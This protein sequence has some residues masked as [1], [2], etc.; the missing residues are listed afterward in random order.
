MEMAKMAKAA[1]GLL[2]I[3][4]MA[5]A[6]DVPQLNE[7]NIDDVLEHMTLLEKATLVVGYTG[8]SGYSGLPTQAPEGAKELVAGAA[9]ETTYMPRFGI[10]HTVQTDGPAGVR[11]TPIRKGTDQTFYCTAFPT[12]TVLAS[13][14][15]KDLLY[16]VGAA[17]GNETREYGM[18]V[19]LAPG[20]NIMRNPLCGRNF[21]YFSEDPILSGKLATAF[22][23][24]VQ[25]Q[26][27]GV[28]VKHFAVNNQESNRMANDAVVSQRA[29]R[30][31]YLKPFEIVVKEAQPWTIMS[32]YNKVNG[33]YAQENRDL[34][35]TILRD[36]W[37]FEGIVMTDWTATRNTPAQIKAGND[38]MMPGHQ[39]QIDGLMKALES[40]E[41]TEEE[42]D[43]CA[44]RVLQYIVKTPRFK[45]YKY[46]DKP[47]LKLHAQLT[48]RAAANSMVLL[49]NNNR[50][51]PLAKGE[52]VAL[53]GVTSYDFVS[54]GT[55][56]GD[57][58]EAYVIGLDEGLKNVGIRVDKNLESNYEQYI[59]YSEG[60]SR[61]TAG[62]S[63][64][65]GAV[66][67]KRMPEASFDEMT[68]NA[69]A[70]RNDV[71]VITIGRNAGEG[72]DRKI[73]GDFNLTD[74]EQALIDGVC[75][76]FHAEGKRVVVIINA[77]GVIETAS[78]KA[79][80]DAILMAWQPGQEGGNSVADVLVGDV[81]PSGKLTMT[82]PQNYDDHASS[83]N[84][85]RD[86]W[87]N[88]DFILSDEEKEKIPSIGTTYY[89]EGIYVGYRYFATAGVEVSYP[90]GY[91]LSY[92]TFRYTDPQISRSGDGYV[93]TVKVTNTGHVAGRE[94][95]QLYVQAPAGEVERPY[96]ELK[97]FAKTRELQP[98]ESETVRM[99]FSNYDLGYYDAEADE[100]ITQPGL[101]AALIGASS[102][103][104]RQTLTFNA[105][106][107]KTTCHDALPTLKPLKELSLKPVKPGEKALISEETLVGT[108]SMYLN[109]IGY[110]IKNNVVISHDEEGWW[111]GSGEL[112]Q[113][114]EE[115]PDG[116]LM[117]TSVHS[118]VTSQMTIIP[119]TYDKSRVIIRVNGQDYNTTMNRVK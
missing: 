98:G 14:W 7:K 57:V 106:T 116:S 12:A 88:N 91:G 21:E 66:E 9:G 34:L 8:G 2:L 108:W 104:I 65:D 94:V 105:R 59:K 25:N 58:N 52:R 49:K 70:Q 93:A 62:F 99:T 54:G 28:S 47:D 75:R 51:L 82:F 83:K 89:E 18:D 61:S 95:V 22:V 32:A 35:T 77:G 24:G 80:P 11:I 109:I 107:Q 53:F 67:I 19:L 117:S 119:L 113:K 71:A 64:V 69:F 55:G 23:N 10:P 81:N 29:L 3:S 20:I 78:W 112:R 115:M 5:M 36:E 84:F 37:G 92:T 87:F 79:K 76:A 40:G 1:A 13:S 4:G 111:T 17:M 27:V 114:M 118:G 48:R 72:V 45:G 90:F 16:E 68:Y 50:T 73:E 101:Y 38:L 103:D 63:S 43:I 96:I 56:S 31:I 6:Q 110:E 100:W 46:S 85:P 102:Q 86:Y 33:T 42:L 39:P 30:E 41:L 97:A 26:G 15:D 60:L 74:K 44:R